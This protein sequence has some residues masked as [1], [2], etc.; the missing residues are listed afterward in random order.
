MTDYC[1]SEFYVRLESKYFYK[2]IP[3]LYYSG[4]VD[5]IYQGLR[6]LRRNKLDYTE[7]ILAKD[8]REK[9]VYNEKYY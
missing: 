5:I 9:V 1:F 6:Y 4:D 7:V 3:L 8:L 2:G